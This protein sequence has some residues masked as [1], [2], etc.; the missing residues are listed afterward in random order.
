[1]YGH[2]DEL[3]HALQLIRR[4]CEPLRQV[5]REGCPG[6][7][8]PM[9]TGAQY[10]RA[11]CCRHGRGARER[12]S[13]TTGFSSGSMRGRGRRGHAAH[14]RTAR[15]TCRTHCLVPSTSGRTAPG[16][17]RSW[18]AE[19]C[20]RTSSET[21]GSGGA[22]GRCGTPSGSACSRP[23]S[24]FP[25]GPACARTWSAFAASTCR[26]IP[27]TTRA[28]PSRGHLTR[29]LELRNAA[30][31]SLVSPSF[32]GSSAPSKQP[33][34]QFEADLCSKKWAQQGSNLWPPGCKPG[35]LP[36][37]YAPVVLRCPCGRGPQSA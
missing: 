9:H 37:S 24:S 3:I 35:A 20:A 2:Q 16:S 13:R 34:S 19:P 4:R 26:T 14:P 22:G 10:G 21:P 33:R 32:R 1:M 8:A 18:Q 25:C 31:S 7:G 12:T 17:A 36:L 23:S 28:G 29:R 30:L 6:M 5:G 27:A 11:Q 15:G